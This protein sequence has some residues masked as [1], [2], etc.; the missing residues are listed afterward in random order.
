MERPA[1]TLW[2]NLVP[3]PWQRVACAFFLTLLVA[4][5]QPP[6]LPAQ[7]LAERTVWSGRLALQV[8]DQAAQSFSAAFE[9][10]GNAQQGE[11]PTSDQAADDPEQDVDQHA[12]ALAFHDQAGQ[13][14]RNTADDDA[15]DHSN[16][17]C[18][19]LFST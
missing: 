1:S 9:L 6:T 11:N 18:E 12:I 15:P 3:A 19:M 17:R 4:C 16:S 10:Q 8:Q 5:T 2:R 14:A 13:P 7:A